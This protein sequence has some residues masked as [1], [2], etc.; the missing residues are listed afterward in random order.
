[1]KLSM[2]MREALTGYGFVLIWI[3]GFLVFTLYP[4]V[5]TFLFSFHS[6]KA[7]TSGIKMSWVGLDNYRNAFF[8]DVTFSDK[9][10]T[11]V[12]QM[13]VYVPVIIVFALIAAM[14]LNT[15][16]KGRGI[17]R[18]IYFLP[19][20]ITSGPV[21][22]QL[23]DQG[24]TSLPGIDQ[25]LTLEQIEQSLPS[26]FAKIVLFLVSSFITILWFSGVQILI[27][28]AGLQKIDGSMMEAA[29]IDGA[30]KWEIFWKLTLPALNPFIVINIV[31]TVIM[32]SIFALNPIIELIQT[33]MYATG[34]GIGYASAL[35]WIYFVVLLI[36][37]GFFVLITAHREPRV[38]PLYPTKKRRDR[39]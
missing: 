1:M 34:L 12:S 25:V 10:F 26:F 21:V 18:T 6:V 9:L 30:S 37:L 14:L 39:R 11:Y 20:I 28:I 24:A 23:M 15:K 33:D 38:K 3:I 16:I 31:Y 2:R 36:I 29:S 22:K 4:L 27:F 13:V 19:V 7:T 5:R 17:F 32:Q 35:A 8:T